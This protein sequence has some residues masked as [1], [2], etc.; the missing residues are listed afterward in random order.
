PAE[1]PVPSPAPSAARAPPA[2]VAAA[3]P[4]PPAP[5]GGAPG[6]PAGPPSPASTRGTTVLARMGPRP[7]RPGRK[8]YDQQHCEGRVNRAS[9]GTL[10]HC[11][12]DGVTAGALEA[13]DGGGGSG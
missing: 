11:V 10:L 4:R 5:G 9:H 1:G 7:R 8:R 3:A 12:F 13:S 6:V 2:T